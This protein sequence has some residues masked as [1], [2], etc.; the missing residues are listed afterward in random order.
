MR[1]AHKAIK[2]DD[3][4]K[5]T[6]IKCYPIGFPFNMKILCIA[7]KARTIIKSAETKFCFER[8]YNAQSMKC[9]LS[10]VFATL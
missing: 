1:F 8:P 4:L 10:A 5:K 9:A 3:G 2:V 6:E 7:F